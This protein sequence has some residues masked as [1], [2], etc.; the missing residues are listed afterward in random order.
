MQSVGTC[1][2]L[3]TDENFHCQQ[4]ETLL[5]SMSRLGRKS[6]P[7]GCKGGGCGVCKVRIITGQ[8]RLGKMS[9][10]HVSLE[11]EAQGFALACRC[12]PS[13][14]LS[15]EVVG[16]MKNKGFQGLAQFTGKPSA[17]EKAHADE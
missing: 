12:Y 7:V 8:Y 16:Q 15:I 5:N 1:H 13:S 11:E 6:I 10:A 14:D 4:E 9:R 17:G 3:D 2:V